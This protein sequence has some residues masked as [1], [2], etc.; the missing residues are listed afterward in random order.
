M[1]NMRIKKRTYLMFIEECMTYRKYSNY[2]LFLI[3]TLLLEFLLWFLL[4]FNSLSQNI[5]NLIEECMKYIY[6]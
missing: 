6:Y 2:E 5:Y 1:V 4:L 3:I